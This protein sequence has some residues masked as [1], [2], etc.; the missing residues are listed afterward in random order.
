M[1]SHIKLFVKLFFNCVCY[2]YCLHCS[3][4]HVPLMSYEE[5][6]KCGQTIVIYRMERHGAIQTIGTPL[7]CISVNRRH[8]QRENNYKV[9]VKRRTGSRI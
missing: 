3:V 1:F 7:A 8:A 6:V 2:K 4:F 5:F 9:L